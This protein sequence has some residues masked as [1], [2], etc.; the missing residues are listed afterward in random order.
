MKVSYS[1]LAS[2]L[3]LTGLTPEDVAKKLTFAGAEVE[4]ISYLA[5][6]NNLI[7]GKII[8]CIE[9]PDSD[10]LHILQ[11][12]EGSEGVHQIVCGAPNARE[13]LKV[14]VARSGAKLPG[15]E[16]K[17]STI[18]GVASDGMCCSLLELGVDPKFLS[19]AQTKGIEELP[20]DAPVGETEVLH[21]LGLDDV[22]LDLSILPN[23][24]DLYAYEN[25]VKEVACLYDL[26]VKENPLPT[27]KKNPTAFKVGS[28]TKKCPLFTG[29]VV[30]GI[31]TKPSPK[32]MQNILTSAGIRSI[33]NVVDIG[34]YVMLLTGQ[35]LN[36]YD[37]DKLP[38]P[39]LDVIDDYEG[40][41][42]AMDG[43][44][45]HLEKGDLLVSTDRRGMCLAGIMTA[46]ECRVDENTT[47]IV[48][49]AAYFDG[50]SIRRT[51][52]RLGLSSDSSLRFCKGIN[53]HQAKQVQELV[54]NLLKDLADAKEIEDIV[55]YDEMDHSIKTIATCLAYI[56][57]RLGTSFSLE[58][59]V[60]T[61]Q[62][63][64][65]KVD[66]QG[67]KMMVEVPSY[68]IDV[69][70]EADLSEEVIRILG[71]EHVHSILP[72]VTLALNGLT[73]K[74]TT[75]RDIKRYLLHR[76]VSEVLT[77]TLL[78]K[79]EA[80]KWDILNADEPYVLAN[81]MTKER[82]AVRTSLIHS[83]LLAAGYNA[84]R[85]IKDLAI[86]EMS[87]VDSPRHVSRHLGLVLLGDKENQGKLGA[88][89]YD[90][91]DL[92]GLLEGILSIYGLGE[93]RY[94]IEKLADRK[95][96]LHPGMSAGLYFGK[97]LVGFLGA[98]HPKTEKE[99]GL[100]HA[101]VMELDLDAINKNKTSP[102]KA[103]IPPKF[104]STR[105][106]IAI[107]LKKEVSYE[108]LRREAMKADPLIK[109]VEIFDLYE[110][111]HVEAGQKS[112]AL[113]LTLFDPN[114]TLKDEEVS[115]AMEKAQK[116]LAYKFGAILRQ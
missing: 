66:M 88:R 108:M 90:F 106:D 61:L 26:P 14:I 32:W 98:L 82:E 42:L 28:S 50:A 71:Y 17:P 84:S 16:I 65:F 18:R 12:D 67:E 34:N 27:L 115:A 45:Y 33:N 48:V 36:M 43:K 114:K 79:E 103:A 87:D 38:S 77:Y 92:K 59:V 40:D 37:L 100:K 99:Y 19:E 105:R 60:T 111:E 2:R 29:M 113:A 86:F 93:N 69:D 104:P 15:G 85:Q 74:Q 52:N 25:V 112:V 75:E 72:E 94:R 58:E 68:R 76:G 95:G 10:H 64:H 91:Y 7:I 46:D 31:V 8:S 44:T 102:I 97:E 83:L 53:P 96:L 3:D 6:G 13:G 23:R 22:V 107:V 73:P 51:S 21:Y 63:D 11:V 1:Y 89:P 54:A 41:F 4:E 81:P 35:P 116:A 9:H 24:P 49:E 20:E 110:G 78:S 55:T 80:L 62:R 70:G 101:L 30:R 5:K 56:N 57:G 47:S 39:Y 109:K